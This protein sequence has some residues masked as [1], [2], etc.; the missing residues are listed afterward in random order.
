VLAAVAADDVVASHPSWADDA[1]L[2]AAARARLLAATG[3][4]DAARALLDGARARAREPYAAALLGL[5]QA[6]LEQVRAPELAAELAASALCTFRELGAAPLAERA[7]A[8]AGAAGA[9]REPAVPR[10][11][12]RAIVPPPVAEGSG[13]RRQDPA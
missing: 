9:V 6:M 5:E 13:H 8:V 12:P 10:L 4:T 7:A 2:L 1:E 3:E 11:A